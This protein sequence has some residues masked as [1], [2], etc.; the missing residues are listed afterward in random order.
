MPPKAKY[1]REE[2]AASAL[3]LVREKGIEALTARELGNRLGCSSRPVFTAFQNMEELK[4]EVMKAAGEMMSSYFQASKDFIPEF[5]KAGMMMIRFAVDEPELFKLLLMQESPEERDFNDMLKIM[6][7]EVDYCIDIIK[8]DYGLDDTRSRR[9]F[10]QMWL[11]S[12]AIGVLCATKMCRFTEE[13]ISRMLGEVFAGILHLIKSGKIDTGV[14]DIQ[15]QGD[16]GFGI[17]DI[18]RH[19]E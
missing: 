11:H 8:R 17:G 18:P 19:K 5:K 7:T 3:D 4:Q 15:V 1:T 13:E 6:G 2:I 9:L 14:T 10:H 12:Y 16:S